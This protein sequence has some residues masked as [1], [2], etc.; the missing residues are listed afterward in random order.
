MAAVSTA[1]HFDPV[2]AGAWKASKTGDELRPTLA[3]LIE[4]RIGLALSL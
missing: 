3:R 2:A 4:Q 1:W